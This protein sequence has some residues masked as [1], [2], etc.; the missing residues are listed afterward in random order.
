[1]RQR[2]CVPSGVMILVMTLA[3]L[4]TVAAAQTPAWPGRGTYRL[5]VDVPAVKLVGRGQDVLV[6]SLPVDFPKWLNQQ[7]IAGQIDPSS[8]QVQRVDSTTGQALP[9]RDGSFGAHPADCPCRFDDEQSPRSDLS[10]VGSAVDS[11]HG[12]VR[13]THTPR[14]AR[15]FNREPESTRGSI[16]WSHWQTSSEKTS[17]AIYFDV[18]DS[19]APLPVGPAPWIGDV[20]VLRRAEGESLGG[21]AH[22][23]VATGDL[24]G[25]GLFD[26]VAGTEKGDVLWFPNRGSPGKPKFVGCHLPEDQHGPIDCGWYAA[27]F[28]YDW[29]GDGL[30]DL[31]CGTRTNVI[32]WWKNVGTK[33]VPAWE[34][35]GF[36]QANEKRLEVP[37]SPVAEDANGIFKVDYYNQPWIGDFNGDGHVDVVTGGYTTGRIYLF[38]GTGRDA[39]GLPRLAAPLALEADGQP[40]DTIWAAAPFVHDFDGDGRMDLVTGT[41]FWSGIPRS[42]APGE[43]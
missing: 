17:Y 27:P 31:L 33:T 3:C 34:H 26:L 13:S 35:V 6:A 4:T 20:D 8:L 14:K 42:P 38:A 37:Q 28:L 40:I 36:L 2:E 10:R 23:T 12:L 32:V 18:I 11:P 1:M 25:D 39:E 41:W 9:Y 24:N 7:G 22:F 19:Q 15:L 16:V 29:N 5:V 21:F 43:G 30:L